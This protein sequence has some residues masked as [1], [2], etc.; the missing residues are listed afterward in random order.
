MQNY[1]ETTLE[2]NDDYEGK[3]I[4]TLIQTFDKKTST[5]ACLHIHGF[6]DYFFQHEEAEKFNQEGYDFYALELRRYNRSK[7]PHQKHFYCRKIDEYFEEITESIIRIKKLGYQK[8][9]LNGHSMGGLVLTSYLE[10]GKLKSEIDLAILNSP[11]FDF[12]MSNTLKKV[13]PLT[14]FISKIF[15]NSIDFLK[16][17]NFQFY[18]HSLNKDHKGEWDFDI[19]IKSPDEA[20]IHYAWVNAMRQ[21][22]L[23]FYKGFQIQTPILLLHSNKS[24]NTKIWSEELF[25]SDAVLNVK[26]IKKYAYCLG[27]SYT[28][29]EIP[30]AMHNI[31]LSAP[32]VRKNAFKKTFSWLKQQLELTV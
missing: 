1:S 19:H 20:S 5:I 8:I 21:A 13:L 16:T 7:L 22:Q 3:V 6:A 31:F 9:I 18:N 10:K 30:N 23:D 26:D 32:K 24:C 28:Q 11:F 14:R 27:N 25:H 4:A 12:P 15:P 2:L 17:H 29:I